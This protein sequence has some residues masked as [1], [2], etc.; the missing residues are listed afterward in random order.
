MYLGTAL[1]IAIPFAILDRE[2]LARANDYEGSAAEEA[3]KACADLRA[4]V[5]VKPKAFTDAQKETARL[6]LCWADQYLYGYLDALGKGSDADE[7]RV[8]TKQRLQIRK[9]RLQHFGYTENEEFA[10]QAD[11]VEIGGDARHLALIKLLGDTVVVCPT[12]KT[13]TN[14]RSVGEKCNNCHTGT[15]QTYTA[16][17]G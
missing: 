10:K 16:T 13:R 15:F 17:E 12:C 11:E 1:K 3:E 7:I 2:D 6:A 8:C 9:V 14:M 5:G 4:L